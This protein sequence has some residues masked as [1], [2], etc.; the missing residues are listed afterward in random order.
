MANPKASRTSLREL[1]QYGEQVLAA[2]SPSP[3]LDAE[4]L[5]AFIT[6]IERYKFL[7][8]PTAHVPPLDVEAY[9]ALLARRKN[10]EPVAYLTGV[11]E[12]YSR[13]FI[14]TPAVLIPRPE[15]ELVVD[16]ALSVLQ[17][18]AITSDKM[19]AIL[20]LGVGS[21]C[22]LLTVIAELLRK[23]CQC[24]G[25][26]VDISPGALE[27]AQRNAEALG[28]TE[29]VTFLQGSWCEPL[30][31]AALTSFDIILA[32]PPYVGE[33][34]EVSPETKFEPHGALYAQQHGLRDVRTILQ[35]AAPFLVQDGTILIEVGAYKRKRL[36]DSLLQEEAITSQWGAL[37]LLGD[38]SEDDR[39]TIIEGKKG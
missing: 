6:K 39:F 26:G 8:D 34:E 22:L 1:V 28:V 20:D 10:R 9:H 17:Q 16:R 18:S 19:I 4:V 23:G 32:N 13:E 38:A 31:T 5:L 37:S 7:T 21:G 2:T 33:S 3:K 36:Q 11:K 12:F 29:R 27:I 25:V 24:R 30:D 35:Q 15:S 14:V